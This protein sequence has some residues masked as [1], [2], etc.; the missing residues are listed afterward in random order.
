M[1][2]I[3]P[4]HFILTNKGSEELSLRT[5]R[6][7]IKLRSLLVL[8]QKCSPTLEAVLQKSIFPR[9][10]AMERLRSLVKEQF[11][12]L[13]GGAVREAPPAISASKAPPAAAGGAAA[14]EPGISLSQARF[15]LGDFCLD[16]FGIEAQHLIDAINTAGDIAAL[17]RVINDLV[18]RARLRRQ[19]DLLAALRQR[20]RDINEAR[21]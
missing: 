10:E 4:A 16:T 11:V 20:I 5:Y 18:A 7:D 9:D 6:L 19:E 21:I 1:G 3:G 13:D 12:V 17:Q 2:A 15:G 14:L 8:I